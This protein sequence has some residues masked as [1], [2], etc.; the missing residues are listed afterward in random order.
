MVLIALP[1]SEGKTAPS[2]GPALD[3]ESLAI[4]E[5]TQ[6]R[7]D[8]IGELETLSRRDDARAVL[9]VGATVEN[10]VVA[11]RQLTRL[12]CAPAHEVY[13]GVL[14]QAAGFAGLSE[15]GMKRA[16]DSVLIFSALFG[17]NSPADLIPRYRLKMGVKLPGGTPKSR[18]RALWHHLDERADRALVIDGRSS[19]YAGWKPPAT[20]THVKIGAVRDTDGTRKVITHNAKYYRGVFTRLSLHADTAP[21]SAEELAHLGSLLDDSTIGDIE[22]TGTGSQLTLTVVE[23][24]EKAA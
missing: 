9:G 15:Q 17:A 6:L 5:F 11:Q 3:L 24:G 16:R 13:T 10:E 4:L 1:P 2:S 14:Y 19:D 20:A 7:S 18:W 21:K 22:L 12:P 23:R 8:L